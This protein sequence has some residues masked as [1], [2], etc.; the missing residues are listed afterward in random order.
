MTSI[1]KTRYNQIKNYLTDSE[2]HLHLLYFPG[3]VY[4]RK[5]A[6]KSDTLE[7]VLLFR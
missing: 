6:S 5:I 1:E 4:K 2:C 3:Q 7:A